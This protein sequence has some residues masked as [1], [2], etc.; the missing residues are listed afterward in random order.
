MGMFCWGNGL[1]TTAQGCLETKVSA[2]FC[3][4]RG[5]QRPGALRWL[6]PTISVFRHHYYN[7]FAVSNAI[8]QVSLKQK[9]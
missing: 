2:V 3:V 5:E 8:P 6:M 4:S 9:L 7:T 1:E